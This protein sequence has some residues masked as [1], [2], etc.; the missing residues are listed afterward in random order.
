MYSPDPKSGS[1]GDAVL[2]PSFE[3]PKMNRLFQINRF[4]LMASDRIPLNR[5]LPDVRRKDCRSRTYDVQ[6]LPTTSIIIVFHNEAWSTL[7]RTVVSAINRSPSQL[8]KEII[9]VDDASQRKFLRESLEKYVAQLAVPVKIIR[10]LKRVGLIKARLLGAKQAKGQV[11]TFLDAHCECTEGW[12]E[13]LLERVERNRKSIVSPVIDIINDETFQYVKSFEMHQGGFNWELHFRWFPL[14]SDIISQR[15]DDPTQPFRTPVIAGG[16]FSM[17]KQ[18][19]YE[20]G[21]Y[22][23]QMQIWGGENLEISFR[24]WMCGAE[25]EI[26]PCSH[27]GHLFRKSS[28]YTFPGGVGDILNSNLARVALVWMDEWKDFYFKIHPEVAKHRNQSISDRLE[29]R[30]RLKCKSFQWF[31][32]T[33]WP[34]N[35][36][37]G[38]DRF[39]GKIRNVKSNKCLQSPRTKT[40]GQPYGLATISDCILELYP[41]Q[42]FV[43]SPDGYIKTDDMVCL[44]PPEFRNKDSEVRIMACNSLPRQKWTHTGSRIVHDLSGKCLDLPLSPGMGGLTLRAC[45]SRSTSQR[46]NFENVK[47]K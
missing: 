43:F 27:V 18:F 7:L 31:L 41:P 5:T 24:G 21:A 33:I 22:D 47:W 45:D 11:L 3:S 44:D 15:Q 40:F 35:F 25:L 16:L 34:G 42:L 28:P 32:K 12:L 10:S 26:V 9:L 37:P 8:L 23:D 36:L 6:R 39:F 4:N 30:S 19:F 29:L 20:L 14:P 13:P 17:D 2:I 46:W 38:D 1:N